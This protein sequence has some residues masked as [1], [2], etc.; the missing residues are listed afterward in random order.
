[1][2]IDTLSLG[3]FCLL[4]NSIIFTNENFKNDLS[5]T[6]NTIKVFNIIKRQENYTF[7]NTNIGIIGLNSA[8]TFAL[9]SFATENTCLSVQKKEKES[10]IE[11]HIAKNLEIHPSQLSH[12]ATLSKSNFTSMVKDTFALVNLCKNSETSIEA[13]FNNSAPALFSFTI[14]F[15]QMGRNYLNSWVPNKYFVNTDELIL[16][17]DGKFSSIRSSY[18]YYFDLNLETYDLD[19]YEELSEFNSA[20]ISASELCFIIDYAGIYNFYV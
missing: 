16:F 15:E 18:D 7:K 8:A 11:K 1:M 20:I 4:Q 12:Y 14:C 2:Q 10:I 13:F 17:L 5:S 6:I 3:T 19:N 9:S